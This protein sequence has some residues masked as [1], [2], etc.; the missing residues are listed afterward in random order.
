MN[1]GYLTLFRIRGIPVRVHWTAPAVALVLGGFQF[2]PGF[3]LGYF[4]VILL[5]ELGHA[6]LIRRYQL[7]VTGVEIHGLGGMCFSE[8]ARSALQRSAIAWGGVLAQAALLVVALMVWTLVPLPPSKFL[9]DLMEALTRYNAMVAGLNLI[10][11]P[12]L[13]GAEAWKFFRLWREQRI[14]RS[15]KTPA[16]SLAPRKTPRASTP[17]DDIVIEDHVADI[18][19]QAQDEARRA[20]ERNQI[21]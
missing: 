5:H 15:T 18:L 16:R 10:P 11:F 3:W 13:D 7:A 20:R 2:V 14:R 19:K 8:G 4:A 1:R 21:H 9:G 6:V 12:P 17:S